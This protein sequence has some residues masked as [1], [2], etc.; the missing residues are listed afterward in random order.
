MK[1]KYSVHVLPILALLVLLLCPHSVNAENIIYVRKGVTG[2]ITLKSAPFSNAKWKVGKKSILKINSSSS[3]KVVYTGKKVGKTALTVYNRRNPS[4]SY[5][6]TVY[7]MPS[8][9]LNKMD[10]ELYGT[11]ISEAFG[12]SDGANAIDNFGGTYDYIILGRGNGVTPSTSGSYFQT[13]RTF[14][15]YDSYNRFCTLY[16]KLS[17]KKYK[18]SKDR[19]YRY[20]MARKTSGYKASVKSFFNNNVKYYV[21]MKYGKNYMIRFLFDRQ[22]KL[23]GIIYFKKYKSL[24]VS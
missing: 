20:V 10:F 14:Q 3:K 9:K 13:A 22:K 5:K 8:G 4:Q 15:F 12:I 24:P 23:S 18:A 19:F 17:L 7:V 2:S 6:W 21:N 11:R 16:G 1:K